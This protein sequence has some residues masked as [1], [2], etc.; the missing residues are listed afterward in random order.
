MYVYLYHTHTHNALGPTATRIWTVWKISWIICMRIHM[1]TRT[2]VSTEHLLWPVNESW[3][4]Q[5]EKTLFTE[6]VGSGQKCTQCLAGFPCKRLQH[7]T[8]HCNMM[9][10]TASHYDTLQHTATHCNT[11]QH[12]A[13]HCNTL[14]HTATHCNTLA[15]QQATL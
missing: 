9:Q 8:T 14:Q 10:C 5:T 7:T 11:L 12:T 6:I 13:T 1:P 2:H 15:A 4:S 3:R